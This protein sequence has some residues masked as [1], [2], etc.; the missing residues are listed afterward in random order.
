MITCLEATFLY[1]F[2]IFDLR[3]G[4]SLHAL[5]R[6]LSA[7][8]IFTAKFKGFVHVGIPKQAKSQTL[9]DL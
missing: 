3:K 8:L 4:L 7:F 2:D 5:S 1:F 9:G 6:Q